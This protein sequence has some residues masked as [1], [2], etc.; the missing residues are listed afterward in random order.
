MG[1]SVH[2][3]DAASLCFE[4]PKNGG[5]P[6]RAMINSARFTK[7]SPTAFG[8]RK[9]LQVMA[10]RNGRCFVKPPKGLSGTATLI[11]TGLS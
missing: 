4:A 7:V 2:Y 10:G 11:N 8:G 9:I 6:S 5:L 3:V 1:D